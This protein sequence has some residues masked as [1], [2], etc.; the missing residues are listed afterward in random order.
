M[1]IILDYQ[2]IQVKKFSGS[3]DMGRRFPEGTPSE[4]VLLQEQKPH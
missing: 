2:N 4:Q 3:Y 1:D